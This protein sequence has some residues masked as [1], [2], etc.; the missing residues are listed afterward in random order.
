MCIKLIGPPP[1]QPPAVPGPPGRMII[2]NLQYT[3]TEHRDKIAVGGS[4][5]ISICN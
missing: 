1:F 3:C 4:I 5:A 2:L